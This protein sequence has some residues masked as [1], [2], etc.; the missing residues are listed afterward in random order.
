MTST[1]IVEQLRILAE[2][3]EILFE[4]VSEVVKVA[5]WITQYV[6]SL[7]KHTAETAIEEN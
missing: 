2:E 6:A 5:N 1:D 7:K 3:E 4:D